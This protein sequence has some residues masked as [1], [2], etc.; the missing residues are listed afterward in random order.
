LS[1]AKFLALPPALAIR[2]PAL[3]ARTSMPS[4]GEFVARATAGNLLEIEEGKLAESR[5]TDAGLKSFGRMMV[6]DHGKAQQELQDAAV[7][8]KVKVG[9]AQLDKQHQTMLDNLKAQWGTAFDLVYTEDQVAVHDRTVSLLL[10][11][12][13]N[14]KNAALKSW[15][16]KTLPVVL[17]HRDLIG[18][19]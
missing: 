14:G 18:G 15:A 12:L 11:Y 9:A 19:M 13:Q 5:A 17:R 10:D 3:H 4:D 6:A 1:P 7:A 16:D 8:G 2:A